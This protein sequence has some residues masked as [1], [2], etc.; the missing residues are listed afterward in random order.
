MVPKVLCKSTKWTVF[1]TQ[2]QRKYIRCFWCFAFWWAPIEFYWFAKFFASSFQNKQRITLQDV[3]LLDWNAE[4]VHQFLIHFSSPALKLRI[5]EILSL[6]I[7]FQGFTMKWWLHS[8]IANSSV[9][10]TQ[11]N[12]II[13]II[14]MNTQP[15]SGITENCVLFN[16]VKVEHFPGY[17]GERDHPTEKC[18]FGCDA[19]KGALKW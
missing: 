5:V 10:C 12:Y 19:W 6:K 7:H 13:Y 11:S 16:C 4:S 3:Y 17:H 2:F 14:L 1:R 8:I 15:I 18:I 9:N